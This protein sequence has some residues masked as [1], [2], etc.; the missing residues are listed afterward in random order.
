MLPVVVERVPYSTLFIFLPVLTKLIPGRMV[1]K[2]ERFA[3]LASVFSRRKASFDDSSSFSDH[4]GQHP[5]NLKS[6]PPQ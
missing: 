1:H 4:S 3:A 5:S 6:S 2:W